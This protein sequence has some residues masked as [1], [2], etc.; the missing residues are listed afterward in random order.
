MTSTLAGILMQKYT[1]M[2]KI[3][4]KIEPTEWLKHVKNRRKLHMNDT[5]SLEPLVCSLWSSSK[6][7][8]TT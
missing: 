1:V 3:I 7:I 2:M 6:V 4:T 8:K 5:N